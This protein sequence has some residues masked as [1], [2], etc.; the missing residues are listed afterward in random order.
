[1]TLV[2]LTFAL[3]FA[4]FMAGWSAR[5]VRMRRDVERLARAMSTGI[6]AAP[7][8]FDWRAYGAFREQLTLA[9]RDRRRAKSPV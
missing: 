4:A 6:A 2:I 8:P 1:M 7:E 3:C 5:A 9:S